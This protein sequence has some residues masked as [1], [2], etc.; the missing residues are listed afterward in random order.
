[1][2]C[3]ESKRN[4]RITER[5]KNDSVHKTEHETD[6]SQL[7]RMFENQN[8]VNET[9]QNK[10]TTS[11]QSDISTSKDSQTVKLKTLTKWI[12]K[13]FITGEPPEK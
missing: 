6:Q 4:K 7:N 10:K 5:I 2:Y 3:N 12:A 13:T 11:G 9:K 8:H 1:M